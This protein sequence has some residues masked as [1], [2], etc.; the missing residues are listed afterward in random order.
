M[1]QNLDFQISE[2]KENISEKPDS[3]LTNVTNLPAKLINEWPDGVL[4]L[5]FRGLSF[6]AITQKAVL[7]QSATSVSVKRVPGGFCAG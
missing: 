7:G 6:K 5:A 1:A 4:T 3:W 2:H